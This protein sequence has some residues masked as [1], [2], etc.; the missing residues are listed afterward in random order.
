MHS[1]DEYLQHIEHAKLREKAKLL[2]AFILTYP[3][4]YC[5]LTYGIPFYYGKKWICYLNITKQQELE[6][7]FTY[8]Y[9]L[10][11]EEGL[12]K[13]NGRKQVASV[14][15][16]EHEELPFEILDSLMLEALKLDQARSKK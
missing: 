3:S 1:P 10:K 14:K 7:A 15:F 9:L 6:F 5:R 8:G 13:S 4:I 16:K 2:H 11:N 12:L